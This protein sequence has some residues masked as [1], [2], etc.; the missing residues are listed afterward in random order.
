[1]D[2]MGIFG[3]WSVRLFNTMLKNLLKNV[4]SPNTRVRNLYSISSTLDDKHAVFP[5][6]LPIQPKKY[7]KVRQDVLF[8]L[9][10]NA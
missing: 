1:M 2:F 6:L 9:K 8:N 3:R 10:F 5:T 7:D 4:Q